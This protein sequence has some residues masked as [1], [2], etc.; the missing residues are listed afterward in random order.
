VLGELAVGMG[1]EDFVRCG[2][3]TGIDRK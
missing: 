2:A 3:V 1:T